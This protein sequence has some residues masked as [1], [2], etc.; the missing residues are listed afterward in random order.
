LVLGL[1]CAAFCGSFATLGIARVHADD[2]SAQYQTTIEEAVREFGLGNW[3]EARA[4]FRRAHALTPSAR[5]FR[6]MGMAAFELKLYVDAL[7]ELTAAMQDTQRPLTDDKRKETQKLIDQSRAYVGRY[8]VLLEPAQAQ[9]WVDGQQAAL[10]PGNLLLLGLG[11]HTVSAVADGY[12]E[13]RVPLRV[14]GSEDMVLRIALQPMAAPA[15]PAPT[16]VPVAEPAPV[17]PVAPP[18]AA[19]TTQPALEPRHGLRTAGFITLGAAALL[20]GGSGVFWLVG[21]GKYTDLQ[22]SCGA[23]GC[24][25]AQIDASGV[26]SADTLTTV[27]LGLS[28]AAA[29]T[30]VVLFIA[31]SGGSSEKASA[32]LGVGPGY[33]QLRG[34][35]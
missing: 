28:A 16:P 17:A 26:K 27:F 13:V 32:S 11:D 33:A 8:Q 18:A 21:S 2:T 15:A 29:V 1:C 31:G 34:S 6:G 20:A 4:L 30:S 14:E 19:T 35:F 7:R 10:E 3:A 5:T 12:Q 25:S 23:T 22:N 24:T 9:A